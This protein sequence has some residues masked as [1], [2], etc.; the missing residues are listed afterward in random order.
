VS[1]SRELAAWPWEL[2]RAWDADV[3]L[4][5]APGVAVVY[6]SLPAP[7]RADAMVRTLQ[8]AL[9]R[10]GYFSG[11]PDGLIG[12]L[13]TE[14][15]VRLQREVGVA[16]DGFAGR[17]TWAA[18]RQRLAA[19]PRRL[20]N[21]VLFRPDPERELEK[22]RGSRASGTGLVS[23]YLRA[24][25]TVDVLDDPTVAGVTRLIRSGYR[26]VPDLV[27]VVAPARYA[28]GAT[29]LDLG[30]DAGSRNLRPGANLTGE[31][32]VTRFSEM[33]ALLAHGGRVP[34]VVLDVPLPSS[35]AE[36][37]RS[38]GVR[39]SFGHQL[40]HLAQVDAILATGLA[41]PGDREELLD[42]VTVGLGQGDDVARVLGKLH[43]ARAEVE[44]VGSVLSFIG[45]ALFADR[46]PFAL[47]PLG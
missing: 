25:F 44:D 8:R 43:H 3:P 36:A 35:P 23:S 20:P 34:L 18:L 12:S 29:V 42:L 28:G 16:A 47:L 22:Q 11:V 39:N 40:L 33:L 4:A 45:S 37:L 32:T 10:L 15:L 24:G 31:L 2:S 26:P 7:R 38:L 9:G 19:E 46:S 5:R 41:G 30:D 1:D 27:H 14:A 6:R 21:A 17:D 13:T